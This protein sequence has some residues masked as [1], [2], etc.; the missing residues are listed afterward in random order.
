[1]AH[2]DILS[3]MIP[4]KMVTITPGAGDLA[5]FPTAGINCDVAG[6]ATV[7]DMHGN[8]ETI[9][10][11]AGYNPGQFRKVT[12]VSGPTTVIAYYGKNA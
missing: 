2:E 5:Q 1:M 11:V 3:G 7:L 12:A 9:A 6:T 4:S 8:T 10:V